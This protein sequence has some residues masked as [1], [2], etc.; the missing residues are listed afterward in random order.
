MD[1]FD[2]FKN[3]SNQNTP[4][5]CSECFR[6]IA[7]YVWQLNNKS[8]CKECYSRNTAIVQQVAGQS[9]EEYSFEATQVNSH[10]QCQQIVSDDG[11]RECIVC[12]KRYYFK[13]IDK[14]CRCEGCSNKLARAFIRE[15]TFRFIDLSKFTDDHKSVFVY[16]KAFYYSENFIREFR[17]TPKPVT[18]NDVIN[19]I[20]D[21]Y[22]DVQ[23]NLFKG[24]TVDNY[25]RYL[26]YADIIKCWDT[27]ECVSSYLKDNGYMLS[28]TPDGLIF[29]DPKYKYSEMCDAAGVHLRENEIYT[30][31]MHC[32][33]AKTSLALFLGKIIWTT[34][35]NDKNEAFQKI[36]KHLTN[37]LYAVLNNSHSFSAYKGDDAKRLLIEYTD[38]Y[39]DSYFKLI[40]YYNNI[41]YL[42]DSHCAS[43]DLQSITQYIM[44]RECWL[45]DNGS[46]VIHSHSENLGDTK[47]I[48]CL[49]LSDKKDALRIFVTEYKDA[50]LKNIFDFTL[51]T[52]DFFSYS[53]EEFK[54]YLRGLSIYT[55][56]TDEILM[57]LWDKICDILKDRKVITNSSEI[58]LAKFSFNLN[59]EI[60][61]D[62]KDYWGKQC[63]YL[64][65]EKSK[66]NSKEIRHY[67]SGPEGDLLV[68]ITICSE[69]ML[70]VLEDENYFKK[71]YLNR[72]NN[73]IHSLPSRKITV[74]SEKNSCYYECYKT[75]SI[76][77]PSKSAETCLLFLQTYTGELAPYPQGYFAGYTFQKDIYVPKSE[78]YWS[79]DQ[80]IKKYKG[81]FE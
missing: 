23:Q 33:H 2:I 58:T 5:K 12:N 61:E 9:P 42:T 21:R 10:S 38:A 31:L 36:V 72:R 39:S 25:T 55:E 47:L 60:F 56:N 64:V 67:I 3:K 7:G 30:P 66:N 77:T 4:P 49:H 53:F 8:Y 51:K 16:D 52:S 19:L 37:M 46:F 79:D 78:F 73:M 74:H 18:S 63:T 81:F 41:T 59:M 15:N 50:I 54:Y 28:I 11:M 17:D 68:D 34:L 32:E 57:E 14:H 65:V 40:N 22:P 70:S 80:I 76:Y 6:P 35:T 26:F 62:A 27:V 48:K 75:I 13:F 24:L 45:S 29:T 71:L 44:L 69:S 20:K 43:K 1:L